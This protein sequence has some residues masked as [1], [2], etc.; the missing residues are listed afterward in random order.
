MSEDSFSLERSRV[1]V[2]SSSVQCIVAFA[3]A[4]GLLVAGVSGGSLE[5]LFVGG[6]GMV[7]SL[8][9]L[10]EATERITVRRDLITIT[11]PPLWRLA[12]KADE[13]VAVEKFTDSQWFVRVRG[14]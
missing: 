12:I 4:S 3:V 13:I 7:G 1:S 11:R 10:S 5:F 14:W 9:L 2:L 8:F 6:I